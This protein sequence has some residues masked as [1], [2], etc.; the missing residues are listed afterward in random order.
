MS[1]RNIFLVIIIVGAVATLAILSTTLWARK[2]VAWIVTQQTGREFRVEGDLRIYPG[3]PTRVRAEKVSFDN[4]DWA[5]EPVMFHVEEAE[6]RIK[7]LRL[8]LGDLIL[9]KINVSQPVV[10]LERDAEG[11]RNNWTLG[12]DTD[13]DGGTVPEIGRLII[14]RGRL[15]F[16][17][18]TTRTLLTL[19]AET[20]EEDESG[21]I[22]FNGSGT[23]KAMQV[24]AQ[25]SGGAVL[26]I[27]DTALPYPIRARFRAG[28]THGSAEGTVSGLAQLATTDLTI[29]LQGNSLEDLYP[30][31]GVALPP[32][33]P[34]RLRGR[35]VHRDRVW[36]VKDLDGRVGD[37]DVAG[38]VELRYQ[39]DRPM[40]TANLHS[41]LFDLDDLGGLIGAPPQTGA[42]ET[43]SPEQKRRAQALKTEPTLLPDEPYHP[44]RLRTMDAD[45]RFKASRV[46]GGRNPLQDVSFHAVLEDGVLVADPLT[47]GVAGGHVVSRL[48]VNARENVLATKT[49]AQ[50]KRIHLSQMF[51]ESELLQQSAG[52]VGGRARL[53]GQG[54]TF[55][56][57]LG[58]SSGSIGLAMRGGRVSNLLLEFTGLDV[59]ETLGLLFGGDKPVAIR[60][61][62]ADFQVTDG[63]M[64]SRTALIDTTDTNI[65]LAGTINLANERVAMTVHPLPKDWSPLSLRSPLHLSGTFKNP[66]IRPDRNLLIKGGLAAILGAAAPVA[67]LLPLI[68]TGPGENVDCRNLISAVEKHTGARV[69]GEADT[70]ARAG[71][72]S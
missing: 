23:Y 55:A 37:S 58:G 66:D 65:H 68:E 7:L 38:D 12:A 2:P 47:F 51:P 9:P 13:G 14:D 45:I 61:A 72:G 49:D 3:W 44:E 8:L 5:R 11:R 71:G 24:S 67:A 31:F 36:S 1:R 19:D 43:A 10:N 62:I 17:D 41:R 54:G 46:R 15:T 33:P 35:V 22:R 20:T 50:F 4:P 69:P 48:E 59:A 40:L 27:R 29:N 16:R 42:G 56:K 30:L 39:D 53:T 70:G 60:C 57:I 32:T 25:G 26:A 18:P 6:I 63:V 21:G 64:K 28:P 52:V 34:Y